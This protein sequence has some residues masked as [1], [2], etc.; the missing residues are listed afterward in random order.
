MAESQ[1]R[2]VRQR[3]NAGDGPARGLCQMEPA[4]HDDC[5]TNWLNFPAQAQVARVIRGLIGNV[6]PSADL[7]MS[8]D[9]Y[10]FAVGRI[11]C[12]RDRGPL[13]AWDDAAGMSAFHKR[14]YNTR[15]GAADPEA[16]LQHFK[17]AIA[18]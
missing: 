9:S 12:W 2:Y 14:V 10:S 7:M 8:N 13:P 17:A 16:N 15:A 3:T 1:L 11:K 5:W 18:A 6:A 4:T